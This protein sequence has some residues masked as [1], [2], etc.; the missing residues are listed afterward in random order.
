MSDKGKSTLKPHFEDVQAHYDLSDDFFALFLDPTRTYTRP[1]DSRPH[2]A[3]MC[4]RETSCGCVVNEPR[5]AAIV[6]ERACQFG[7]AA[8]DRELLCADVTTRRS[9]RRLSG[10]RTT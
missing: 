5:F 9:S 1:R 4:S 7:I 3:R 10:R 8:P 2:G 6:V